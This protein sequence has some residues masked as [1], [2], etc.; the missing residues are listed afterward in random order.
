MQTETILDRAKS[1]ADEY[2]RDIGGVWVVLGNPARK[3]TE[4]R[5]VCIIEA[6]QADGYMLPGDKIFYRAEAV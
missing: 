1:A 5:D 4:M 3:L 6:D 2:A